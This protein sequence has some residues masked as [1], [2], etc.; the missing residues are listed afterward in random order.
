[1]NKGDYDRGIQDF[2]QAIKLNPDDADAFYNR[3]LAYAHKRQCDR[4]IEDFNRASK[5]DSTKTL[6]KYKQC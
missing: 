3:G 4:A 5:L 6:T 1:M 2:N